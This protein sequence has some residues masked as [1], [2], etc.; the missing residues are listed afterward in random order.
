[1]VAGDDREALSQALCERYEAGSATLTSSGTAALT[2]ALRSA[3][4]AGWGPA[5]LPAYCC[6]DLVTAAVGAEMPVVLYDLVPD[7]LEPDA[8]S[9][10]AA[11][12][13]G[14][15]TL[16]AAHLFGVPVST[17]RLRAM[18]DERGVLL[19]EDAAQEAGATV[20]GKRAGAFGH[21]T[22]LSF[23]RGKGLTGGSGG[24]LL[25]RDLPFEPVG[26]PGVSAGAGR[27]VRDVAAAGALWLL[28]R[29]ALFGIPRALP[30]LH[31]GE[32]VYR[33]PVEPVEISPAAASM[34][35]ANL[36]LLD[37][38][39]RTRQAN[40]SRLMAA[41]A[42]ASDARRGVRPVYPSRDDLSAGWLRLPVLVP[43]GARS[44]A[45]SATAGR[46]GI[47][48]GY[49]QPLDRLPAIRPLLRD[50]GGSLP[51]AARLAEELCTLAVHGWL[52]ESD[53]AAVE[54]MLESIA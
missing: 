7:T 19:I 37:E 24:A 29:P 18:C 4:E 28:G 36:G 2:L 46:L 10:A 20:G 13:A 34:V 12:D 27:G 43:A 52:S 3:R 15:R 54:E 50:G 39:V 22:V 42:S 11:L 25:E 38:E 23:G 14:A 31:V 35:L 6:Y 49:P 32:T 45:T 1:M 51:G 17:D 21:F 30:G 40:A 53:L 9:L 8:D 33:Q 26:G 16:V 41:L 47:A 48:A 44:D 5:A